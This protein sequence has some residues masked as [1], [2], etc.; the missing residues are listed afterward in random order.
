MQWNRSVL[1][2]NYKLQKLEKVKDKFEH[3]TLCSTRFPSIASDCITM[4]NGNSK[5]LCLKLG[6]TWLKVMGIQK[7]I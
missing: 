6:K 4:S 3:T 2:N 5:D 1:N 7:L